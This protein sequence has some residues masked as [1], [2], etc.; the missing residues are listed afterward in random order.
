[1]DFK[2]FDINEVCRMLG[3]TSRTLRFYEE[4]GIITSTPVP[5]QTRRQYTPEQ[6]EHIKKVL[7]LRS[8]GL[9]VRKIQELQ[10]KNVDLSALITEHKAELLAS[11][12]SK[13]KEL[14]LLDEALSTLDRGGDIFLPEEPSPK[15]YCYDRIEIAKTFTDL[16]LAENYEKCFSYFTEMLQKYMP[17]AVFEQAALDTLKPLGGFVRKSKIEQDPQSKN[18]IYSYLEY[19]KLGMYLKMVFHKDLIHGIWLNYYPLPQKGGTR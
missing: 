5:F 16:F 10:R 18:V 6:I 19:E 4:K 15:A 13:T 1:M 12:V 7:V 8:L 11:M 9:P 17:L 3:T 14:H 2:L